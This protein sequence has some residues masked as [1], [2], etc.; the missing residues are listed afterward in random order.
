MRKTIAFKIDGREG[1]ITVKELTVKEILSLMQDDVLQDTSLESLKNIFADRFLPLCVEG[2][3]L[4]DLVDF[5]PSEIEEVWIKFEE[6]NSSFFALARKAGLLQSVN[7]IKDA[8]IK[9]FSGLLVDS[10]KQ[11]TT[12]S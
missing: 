2:L 6:V 1:Q 9:D 4:A 5:A 7:N 3:S 10:S 12:T 8:I 11:D